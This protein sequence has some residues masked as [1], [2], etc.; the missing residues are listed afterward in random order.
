MEHRATRAVIAPL[1]RAGYT[2]VGAL[3]WRSWDTHIQDE[4]TAHIC[5]RVTS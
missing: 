5:Y 1:L 2:P 3:L 4:R